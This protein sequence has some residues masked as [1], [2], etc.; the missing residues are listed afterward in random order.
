[1]VARRYEISDSLSVEK[2]FM[3]ERKYFT[4]FHAKAP[5]GISLVFI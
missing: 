5:F 3:S 4:S 2:Y 1:M